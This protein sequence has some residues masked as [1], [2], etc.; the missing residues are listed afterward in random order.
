MIRWCRC[1]R[2][3]E[4][5]ERPA[6]IRRMIAMAIIRRI[7][8]GR[9]PFS[10]DREHLHHRIMRMGL[11]QQRTT[12]VLYLWTAMFAIPTAVAAFIPFWFA[13]LIGALIFGVSVLVIRQNKNTLLIEHNRE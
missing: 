5:G 11:T 8:A 2:S 4:N 12:V 3:A 10:A 13:L 6:R 9:S 1:S 7:R